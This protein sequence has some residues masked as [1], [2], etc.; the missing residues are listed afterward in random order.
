MEE[1]KNATRVEL[2]GKTITDISVMNYLLCRNNKLN[3]K[4]IIFS[5]QKQKLG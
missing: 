3:L 2:S 5:K 1:L 4:R